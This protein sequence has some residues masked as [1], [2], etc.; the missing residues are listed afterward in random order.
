MWR[1]E[2]ML[3][4]ATMRG[5]KMSTKEMCDVRNVLWTNGAVEW[6]VIRTGISTYRYR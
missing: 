6:R 3:A 1:D 5:K 4:M 2:T